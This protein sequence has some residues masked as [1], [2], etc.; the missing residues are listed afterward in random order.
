V[1]REVENREAYVAER[2]LCVQIFEDAAAVGSAVLL[3]RVHPRHQTVNVIANVS[4]N[5]AHWSGPPE[6]HFV[7]ETAAGARSS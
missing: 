7:A 2:C 5:S 3:R 4:R 6:L 1:T